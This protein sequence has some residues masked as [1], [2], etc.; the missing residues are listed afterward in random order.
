MIFT[1]DTMEIICGI[2]VKICVISVYL[3]SMITKKQLKTRLIKE[4][5][6]FRKNILNLLK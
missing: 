2:S 5:L 6:N 3:K 4:K 1:N